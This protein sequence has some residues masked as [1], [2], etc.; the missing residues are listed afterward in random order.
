MK[1]QES[2]SRRQPLR[3]RLEEGLLRTSEIQAGRASRP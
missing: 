2:Y 3:N 1:A